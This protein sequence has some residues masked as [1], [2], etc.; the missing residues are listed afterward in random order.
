MSSVSLDSTQTLVLVLPP[1]QSTSLLRCQL[2]RTRRNSLGSRRNPPIQRLRLLRAGIYHNF[3]IVRQ[4]V[5]HT[6]EVI[7]FAPLTD[8]IVTVF[9]RETHRRRMTIQQERSQPYAKIHTKSAMV[10]S[11][12]GIRPAVLAVRASE[13][14]IFSLTCS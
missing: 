5:S 1:T 7:A 2:A 14:L 9:G 3:V 8:I 4:S 12:P 11:T 13:N 6:L 10:A